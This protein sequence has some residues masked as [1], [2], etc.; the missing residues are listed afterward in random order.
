MVFEQFTFDFLILVIIVWETVWKGFALWKSSRN[1]QMYWF[2]AILILNTVGILP[3][4]YLLLFQPKKGKI[5]V[6][7]SKAP[8]KKRVTKKKVAR[9]K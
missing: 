9:K 8:V 3:I 7:P 6:T 4:L 5:V 1:N 2:I